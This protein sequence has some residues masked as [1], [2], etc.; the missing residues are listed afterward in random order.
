VW[1]N[2]NLSQGT[3]TIRIITLLYE[4]QFTNKKY[5]KDVTKPIN[6]W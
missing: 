2:G 1:H 4:C 5:K 3:N 6:L